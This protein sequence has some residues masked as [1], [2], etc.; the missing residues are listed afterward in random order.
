MDFDIVTSVNLLLSLLVV[1]SGAYLYRQ[2]RGLIWLYLALGFSLFALSHLVNLAGAGT[3]LYMPMV[4]VRA[5]GYILILFGAYRSVS[6]R[7]AAPDA[8]A[9]GIPPVGAGKLPRKR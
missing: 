7:N 6:A 8:P 9:G 3:E 1:A 2:G 5:F 4:F